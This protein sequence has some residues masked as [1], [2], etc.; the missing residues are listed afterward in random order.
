[1][2]RTC[3]LAFLA[4]F[5]SDS[6]RGFADEQTDR[7]R[8]AKAALAVAQSLP[9]AVRTPTHVAPTPRPVEPK[10]YAVGTKE[11]LLDQSPLIVYVACP[12][13]KIEGAIVCEVAGPSFGPVTGP[14]VVVGYPSGGRLLIESTLPCPGTVSDIEAAV[15]AASKKI[16][17]PAAKP[18][19]A[20]P[21]PLDTQ[22]RG[23]PC[24]CGDSCRCAAGEC[25]SRCPVAAKP[26]AVATATPKL[27]GYTRVC[28]GGTC[29]LVPVY[30]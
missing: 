8:R 6:G 4:M 13:I 2:F 16:D 5:T 11:S 24:I 22:I 18:M 15:K 20:A 25:P 7:D 14:A 28:N 26:V 21:K 1:M 29:T 17:R 3:L 27:V 30:R 19:P 12:G 10:T 23:G 9:T